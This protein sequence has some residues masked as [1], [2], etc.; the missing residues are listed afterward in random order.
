MQRTKP[1]DT[2]HPPDA[3][4]TQRQLWLAAIKLPMYSVAIVPIATGTA[5]AYAET[6]AIAWPI[7]LTFLGAAVAILAWENLCNDVFDAETGI[8]KNKAHSVVNLT[9]RKQG[10]FW[11][12]N[13]C[14]ALGLA[15]VL[16]IAWVQRDPAVLAAIAL[17]CLLGYVY[18]GPPFR[19]GYRGWGEVLCFFAFGPLGVSAAYYSQTQ[20]WSGTVLWAAIAVGLA[21]SLIL[22]CS[23]FHQVDDDL[24]AGKRS[25]IVK[26]GTERAAQ[27]LP[28]ICS[29][30][31]VPVAIGVVSGALPVGTLLVL[32][33]APFAWKLCALVL[34]NHNV[35]ERIR[36]S[37]FL[38]VG[39]HFWSGL[40][41]CLGMV[42]PWG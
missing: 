32:A 22:Y 30:I 10:I 3:T 6:G 42:L 36:D 31:F 26:L 16:G 23:H 29:S 14:L 21:T 27:F 13:A 24:A 15:G 20:R 19:W 7:F 25:P 41:L 37:K 5:I 12:A 4:P 33:G 18:Q 40:G 2:T 35:P 11:L 17:C 39:V 28:W 1:I 9:G 8:D 34:P 38:A